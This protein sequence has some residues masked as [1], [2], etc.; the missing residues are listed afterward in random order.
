MVLSEKMIQFILEQKLYDPSSLVTVC[1]H[2]L[3]ILTLGVL[4]SN[5]GQ[6]F[7]HSRI[8]IGKT[9]WVGNIELH[10]RTSDWQLHK[11]H[12]DKN[13]TN[14][15]LHVV[16][17][18]D[19]IEYN[20][21]P[22]L[23]LRNFAFQ[24]WKK[25]YLNGMKISKNV[26]CPHAFSKLIDS[27]SQKYIS[28]IGKRRLFRKASCFINELRSVN[29]DWEEVS[30][31]MVAKN[32]GH[33]VN[34]EGFYQLA[35][36]VEFGVLKKYI[37]DPMM[38]EAILMGQA[39]LLN[40]ELIDPYPRFLKSSYSLLKARHGLKQK[41]IKV[42][43]LRMR[44]Q[45]FPTIRMSQLAAFYSEVG[46]IFQFIDT[47]FEL[48]SKLIRFCFCASPYWDTHF[49]FDKL[50]TMNKKRMGIGFAYNLIINSM[51]PLLYAYGMTIGSDFH[52]SQAMKLLISTPPERNKKIDFF[53]NIMMPGDAFESQSLIQLYDDFCVKGRC[54][55]C[56]IKK[57]PVMDEI[58]SKFNSNY[59]GC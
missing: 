28:V 47:P 41:N 33:E 2:R 24:D 17:I 48:R 39:G 38:M 55:V 56:K 26:V 37:N 31:R 1:G 27:D 51:A 40:S 3:T 14:T 44:P 5:Q 18:H 6:D 50:S 11:H 34:S 23:E 22:V 57:I 58:S 29:G 54:D 16:W 10:I 7:I 49:I 12:L 15:V 21:S 32:F 59:S 36:S 46:S 4:N 52:I 53:K 13:Y 25:V 42:Y 45:N 8:I 9:E 20:H 30:W 19:S 35:S 43:F